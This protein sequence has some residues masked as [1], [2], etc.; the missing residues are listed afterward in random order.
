MIGWKVRN[1]L[2]RLVDSIFWGKELAKPELE[3]CDEFM[4]GFSYHDFF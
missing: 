4:L 1:F 2:V 3:D